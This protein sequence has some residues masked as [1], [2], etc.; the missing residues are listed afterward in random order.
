MGV[1]RVWDVVLDHDNL[2]RAID[3]TIDRISKSHLRGEDC[4]IYAELDKKKDDEGG[5][6]QSLDDKAGDS[7]DRIP[8]VFPMSSEVIAVG[9]SRDSDTSDSKSRHF[10]PGHDDPRQYTL[11]KF[12]ELNSGAVKL[13]LDS[14]DDQN[15]DLPFTPGPKEHEVSL[16]YDVVAFLVR[17][18][19]TR[20]VADHIE[21]MQ[22][23]HYKTDPQRSVL[24]MGRSGTGKT[25]CLVFRMWAQY[26]S[27][28]DVSQ[29][30]RPRQ[31]F[32]TKNEVLCREV[33]RSFRNMGLAWL[34]RGASTI[35]VREEDKPKFITSAEWLDRLDVELPGDR[36][37]TGVELKQRL[38]KRKHNDAVT[39]GIE[40]LLSEENVGD[41]SDSTS[42]REEMTFL[43][44]RRLWR[45]IRSGSGSQID[46]TMVWRE[47][48]SF[49][50]GSVA[51]LHVDKANEDR[52]VPSNRFLSL[53]EYLALPRKQSRMDETQRREIYDLFLSYEK[54]KRE[55]NYYDEMDLVYNLAGRITLVDHSYLE[56][57]AA[58]AEE[59]DLLPIDSLFVDEVQDF[60]QAELYVLTK[61]CQD[62]NN[63]FLAGD[64][65]QS[66]AVG[67]D[68]RFTDVRQIFYN[69]FGGIE[70]KLLQL[71]HNYRSHAGVL[72]LAACVVELL[73]HFFGASLD[74]LPPDLGL[75]DGPKPVIMDVGNTH[76]LLLMLQGAKR[77][78]SRIEFGAHQVVIVRNEEA[79]KTLP[80]EFGID[81]D[82]V[83]TV[84][85][86]KGLEDLWR[87]ASN[88]SE[89]DIATY[90]ADSSVAASGVQSYD[91]DDAILQE[92]RHLDFVADQHKILETELKMLYTAITRA[93][94][95]I[96]IAETNTSQSLPMFNY[97]QRRRVV[98]V[99][100]KDLNEGGDE[101]LSGVR[102]FGAMNSVDDWRNRGEYYLR[103]AEGE[104]QI[105]C[106]RLAAK[107]FDKAGEPAR[108]NHALAC[109]TFAEM[110]NQDMSK[111]RGKKA[112]LDHQQKLYEITEQLLE[113]RDVGFLDKAALC[114]LR[115]GEQEE[116]T[117]KLFEMY[118]KL[119][120]TQRFCEQQGEDMSPDDHEKKYFGY[121]ARLFVKCSQ[122]S[123][124]KFEL[125]L[126]SFRNLLAAGMYQDAVKL[127]ESE[128]L[129][130][131]DK[132][133][134]KKVYDLYINGEPYDV[135]A[136]LRRS[137]RLRED[138]VKCLLDA[139]KSIAANF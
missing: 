72:R 127:I 46:G 41:V 54:L 93:R 24:L 66:I 78:T 97:F 68:F 120:Y 23:I 77:E 40:A 128:T 18:A 33:E 21:T 56:K 131:N 17:I 117:A 106:L 101:E 15:M 34:K 37:F 11:L 62:P 115:T 50:K 138:A 9:S 3:Q 51:A 92:T 112:V 7:S 109:L 57:K 83:M 133:R 76:E 6:G 85:E 16:Y 8:R 65:A 139:L 55:G 32:V 126:D 58:A 119:R 14:K 87:V 5:P 90:Y 98:D 22:I 113:A 114:L 70:P 125:A 47:I 64:T 88:Y 74:R 105:G 39:K 122:E 95:N 52:K 28:A 59:F 4:A 48:K 45:K 42:H 130:V 53:E 137:L 123:G 79:K 73:Y 124:G 94:I 132:A 84:Q 35:D 29:G 44:F 30:P 12:Y 99:V 82:W 103:N 63:L 19:P 69:S 135:L 13:L 81:P 110:D 61:L 26:A 136:S 100:N 27:Y 10:H 80:N 1:I 25:T 102:V 49:I 71:S 108:K 96:F 104:R 116:Y 75:F 38:D 43:V 36:F 121:A 2:S 134:V 91:W 60:T 118:G 67:V 111:L 31:L 107:C 89:S 129:L 86:S 20:L